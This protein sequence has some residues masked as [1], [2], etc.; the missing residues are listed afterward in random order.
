MNLQD[1]NSNL[2][3]IDQAVFE[4]YLRSCKTI[5]PIQKAVVNPV[6][7][8]DNSFSDVSAFCDSILQVSKKERKRKGEY[9]PICRQILILIFIFL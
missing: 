1:S 9:T 7:G 3:K 2:N 6:G 8:L 4:F 5:L